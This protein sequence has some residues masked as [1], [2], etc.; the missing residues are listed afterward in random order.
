MLSTYAKGHFLETNRRL[1]SSFE[2]F[3]FV[4]GV[5][6]YVYACLHQFQRQHWG[7]LWETRWSA[8]GLYPAHSCHIELKRTEV[9]EFHQAFQPY[10]PWLPNSTSYWCWEEAWAIDDV[11]LSL[12]IK[13]CGID[14]RTT[15]VL[16]TTNHKH[17]WVELF[18][19]QRC[20][21]QSKRRNI[22]IQDCELKTDE[23]KLWTQESPVFH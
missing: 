4:R 12:G 11:L 9:R 21:R 17:R 5:W 15:C 14:L 6:K 1:I 8:Y 2:S 19:N 18:N 16:S 7:N 13:G 3:S 20:Y 10:H 23:E 22:R